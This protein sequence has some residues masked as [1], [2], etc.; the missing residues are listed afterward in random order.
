MF[1]KLSAC[2]APTFLLH[3]WI[4]YALVNKHV[5]ILFF[6]IKSSRT[7][8]IT[9][10]ATQHIICEIL[11]NNIICETYKGLYLNQVIVLFKYLKWKNYVNLKKT[12]NQFYQQY[13]TLKESYLIK[14]YLNRQDP[15]LLT[16]AKRRPC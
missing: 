12:H 8:A 10:T 5:K 11:Y 13:Q 9:R 3:K 6:D 1:F 15:K 16:N 2:K 4:L 7:T 14:I